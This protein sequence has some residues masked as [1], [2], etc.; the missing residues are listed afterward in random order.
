MVGAYNLSYLKPGATAAAYSRDDY[1]APLVALWQR[2]AGRS[3]AVS[4]PLAGEGAGTVLAWSD[5]PDLVQTLGRWVAGDATPEGI[6]VKARVRG[7]RLAIELFYDERWESRFARA[8]PEVVVA[9]S[10]GEAQELV[11]ERLR[12]GHFRAFAPLAGGQ[13]LSGAIRA[14]EHAIPFGPHALDASIEWAMPP[15]RIQELDTLSRLSGGGERLNLETVW[16][17]DARRRYVDL[18]P[19]LAGLLLLFVLLEAA[20]ARLGFS[21]VPRFRGRT[22]APKPPPVQAD[23][24]V[25]GGSPRR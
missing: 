2:G 17:A 3:A 24:A 19:W 23:S 12:P 4:F 15:Q 10:G 16:E 7:E 5:Y 20:Q 1:E 9:G 22:A 18:R 13:P 14:G 6:A 25:S 21:L 8:M 11:W